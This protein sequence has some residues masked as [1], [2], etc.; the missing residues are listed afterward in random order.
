[1]Q[2]S[3]IF[4]NRDLKCGDHSIS[5]L[6]VTELVAAL[7]LAQINIKEQK[8]RGETI[9]NQPAAL[10]PLLSEVEGA[11]D[12]IAN[13]WR[14][15]DPEYRADIFR[16]IMMSLS[17][18]YF[19]YFHADG[20]HPDWSPLWNPVYTLQP[21][22]DDIYL[23]SPLKPGL[24][25]RVSGNRGTVKLL[26]FSTGAGMAGMRDATLEDTGDGYNDIDDTE[27][28]FDENGDFEIL[29]CTQRPEAHTG[30]WGK[31]SPEADYMMTRYR[32]Y[33]WVNEIDPHMTI[34]CLDSVPPKKRL[35]P[36]DIYARIAEMAKYPR[37]SSRLFLAMQNAIKDRVGINK[38]EPTKYAGGLSKQI[39]W[40]A[41]F[42]IEDGEALIIKTELPEIC[43][44][45]NIQINDPYF[46][47]VEY[48]YRLSSINGATGKISADGKLRAVVALEDPGVPNWLDTAGFKQGTIYGRWYGCDSNP[49]PVL[50]RV[51]LSELR[52]HLPPDTPTISPDERAEELRQRVRGAQSRRRW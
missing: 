50:K 37:R 25:Y 23:Y 21:N 27:M 8:N 45:W 32:S 41:V 39:Y 26:T 31:L 42:E 7:D 34:E 43:P 33:D 10:L 40:P 44:Y 20:E 35:T 11:V 6:M 18:S 22:P 3:S 49:L 16:Q 12:E 47:I 13:T 36:E 1:M 14:P 52:D 4:R 24:H 30:N 46:S 9:L 15:D 19:A 28:A 48:V 17:F 38:F 2:A 51:K 5:P 29:F